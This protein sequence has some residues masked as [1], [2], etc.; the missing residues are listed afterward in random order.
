MDLW[1]GINLIWFGLSIGIASL[2]IAWL[3]IR[4]LGLDDHWDGNDFL[5]YT[6]V[7]ARFIIFGFWLVSLF[8]RFGFFQC[9]IILVIALVASYAILKGLVTLTGRV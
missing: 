9:T 1:L 7:R 2:M 4:G 8:S 5:K 6:L 3:I